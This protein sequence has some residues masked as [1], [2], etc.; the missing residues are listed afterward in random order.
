M[1]VADG[2]SQVLQAAARAVEPDPALH[3]DRWSEEHVVIPKGAAFSGPYR[4]AH[5][6]PARRILQ[7]LS[8]VHPATRIVVMAASQMLKT[9]VAINAVLGWID[10]APANILALEPTD[11]LAKR[12][13]SRVSKA[14]DACDQVRPKV[15]KPRS[16]DSRNTVDTKEFDGGA[17]YIATSGAAANLAEIP[18]RYVFVDEVDRMEVNIGGE[19]DPV[20]IAEARAT[21]YEGVAKFYEVSS[22]TMVGVSKITALYEQ[23]TRETYHVPCPHC[24]HLHELQQENFRYH[25]DEAADVVTRAWFVCPECGAEIEESCKAQLLADEAMG[26]QARWVATSQGDGETVSF[27]I[28]AFYAP[29]GSISWLR[30]A[31]QHARAVRRKERGDPEAMKV[32]V[33]TRLGLPYDGSEATTTVQQL[34]QRAE[35]YPARVLPPEAL[36]LTSWWDTQPNRLEGTFVAWGPGLECWVLDHMILWGSPTDDPDDPAS[37]WARLDEIRRTPLSHA[38]GV[39]V[40][41][42]AYGIDSGGAN[43]QDVYN[44][45]H[46]R[47]NLGCLVTKGHSLPGRPI[48]ASKPSPVDINWQGQ[49]VQDGVKLWMLGADTAKDHLHNRLRLVDGPGAMHT[50][51]ALDPEWFE[52]FLAER[53]QIRY[54]KGR[55]IREWVKPNGARNEAL[56]CMVGNLAVAHYL[57][58]HRW[59]A[60]DWKRLRDNLIPPGGYTPD[61]FAADAAPAQI[62]TEVTPVPV[63]SVATPTAAPTPVHVSAQPAASAGRRVLSAGLRR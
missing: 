14:I 6:P 57:G 10:A 16:R 5:T 45:G 25:Y 13:S 26:G 17:V 34:Q 39:M 46:A 51:A 47:E 11:K 20:E 41:M 4:I 55:A 61:L 35:G 40:K 54:H 3:L 29:M 44:Y 1:N 48:I 63:K 12:L 8:P 60:A 18:A 53:P 58:L 62:A 32:Y 31:R 7:C 33:N 21:T 23:G 15:A 2:F 50:H 43:T 27:H 9:Q 49:R 59:S 22:P 52:Q 37:V 24:G 42:S 28:S 56:D 19:G 30:L 36:V 38:C